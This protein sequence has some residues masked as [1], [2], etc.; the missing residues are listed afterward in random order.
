MIICKEWRDT[1]G[2]ISGNLICFF[3]FYLILALILG[4]NFNTRHNNL[5]GWQSSCYNF[6]FIFSI[7]SSTVGGLILKDKIIYFIEKFFRT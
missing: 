5:M 3:T 2:M 1:L 4:F 6:Y 7:M